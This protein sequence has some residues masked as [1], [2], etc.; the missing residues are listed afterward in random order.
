LKKSNEYFGARDG[1]QRTE[2]APIAPALA[3]AAAAASAAS[4]AEVVDVSQLG[5]GE[6]IDA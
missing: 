6:A 4:A 2:P 3:A 5:T 1:K